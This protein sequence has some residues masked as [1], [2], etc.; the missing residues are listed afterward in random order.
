MKREYQGGK[1]RIWWIAAGLAIATALTL[2]AVWVIGPR[3][4][5]TDEY[6]SFTSPDGNYRIVVLREPVWPAVLPGQASD[7]PGVVRLYDR[8]GTVLRETRV[9]MVQLVE[10]VEWTEGH[11][12]IKLIAEWDLPNRPE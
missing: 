4:I 5:L 10:H 12:R 6:A 8:A 9:A 11:V 1:R 3:R 7:A 2:L